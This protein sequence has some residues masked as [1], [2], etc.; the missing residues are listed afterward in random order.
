MRPFLILMI[1]LTMTG[2]STMSYAETEEPEY[3]L[4]V[5][6]ESFEIRQYAD[7]IIAEVEV[8]GSSPQAANRGFRV[9]ADFI[10]GNNTR[11]SEIAMTAPVTQERSA[12]I[13]MT[14]PVTQEA[15]D[16][17]T[18]RM[19]FTMPAKWTMETLPTPN[20][21]EVR[22]RALPPELLAAVRFN[23]RGRGKKEA[24]KEAELRDWAV[25]QGYVVTGAM[26]AAY[27]DPPWVLPLFRRNEVLLP[28]RTLD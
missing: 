17:D 10:F 24:R 19:T 21:P 14:A 22:L 1:I 13:A 5:Q 12:K 16:E 6:E 15:T 28:I 23:G 9:L 7:R 20:N 3:E 2:Q 18:W 26:M 4:I 25:G 11:S 8:T 27:Y